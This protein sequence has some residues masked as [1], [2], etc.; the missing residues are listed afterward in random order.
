MTT[1]RQ[2]ADHVCERSLMSTGYVTEWI[3][4]LNGL[5]NPDQGEE[6]ILQLAPRGVTPDML[7]DLFASFR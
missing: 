5:V 3:D 7:R 4:L 6:I 2:T 1:W